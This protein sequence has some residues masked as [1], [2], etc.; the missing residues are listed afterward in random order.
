MAHRRRCFSSFL[1]GLPSIAGAGGA[2]ASCCVVPV[3]QLQLQTRN[4]SD[5]MAGNSCG[6]K[7]RPPCNGSS[8]TEPQSTAGR[9]VRP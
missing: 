9:P 4:C 6:R 5:L 2:A 7:S 1:K 3:V 8:G